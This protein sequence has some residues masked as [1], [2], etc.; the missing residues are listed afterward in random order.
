MH[1]E[2]GAINNFLYA[3]N[4]VL[5]HNFLDSM[6]ITLKGGKVVQVLASDDRWNKTIA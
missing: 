5:V 2:K 1:T 3:E 4:Y 6:L